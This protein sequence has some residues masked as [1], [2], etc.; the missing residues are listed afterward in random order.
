VQVCCACCFATTTFQQPCWLMECRTYYLH[1]TALHTVTHDTL[2]F[3][4]MGASPPLTHGGCQ[5]VTSMVRSSLTCVPRF[6]SAT[7]TNDVQADACCWMDVLNPACCMQL[8]ASSG[9]HQHLLNTVTTGDS[10]LSSMVCGICW[11]FSAHSA[12]SQQ[13]LQCELPLQPGVNL[14]TSQYF[15][16]CTPAEQCV[17]LR[18]NASALQLCCGLLALSTGSMP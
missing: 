8:A 16:F 14:N 11:R 6:V 4:A 12:G 7:L 18:H 1:R 17:S 10:L 15:S 2:P 5:L 9:T 3:G 13:C